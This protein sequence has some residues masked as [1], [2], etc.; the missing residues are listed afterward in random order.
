MLNFVANYIYLF[1]YFV[2]DAV[3]LFLFYNKQK[4]YD[5]WQIQWNSYD[6]YNVHGNIIF[7]KAHYYTTTYNIF[8]DCQ[9]KVLIWLSGYVNLK[10][11][12]HTRYMLWYKCHFL[13]K[14]FINTSGLEH[15]YCD[16]YFMF[17]DLTKCSFFLFQ[18]RKYIYS[19]IIVSCFW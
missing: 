1:L 18:S 15:L 19:L 13:L 8:L 14:T 16:L 7:F 12:S 3:Y 9:V 5:F 4:T 6:M 2:V 10:L 11:L 17:R